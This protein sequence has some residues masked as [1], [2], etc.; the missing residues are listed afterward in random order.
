MKKFTVLAILFSLISLATAAAEEYIGS[1]TATKDDKGKVTAITFKSDDG[2]SYLVKVNSGST[3]LIK[4]AEGKTIQVKGKVSSAKNKEGKDEEWLNVGGFEF[5]AKGKVAVTKEN[6]K[7][8]GVSIGS[9]ELKFDGKAK[10]IAEKAENK[11]V[12]AI[13]KYITKSVGKGKEK[14]DKEYFVVKSFT[15]SEEAKKQE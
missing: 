12:V 13:G 8:T 7:I 1:A 6:T 5:V 10:N 15:V 14:A 9:T 11:E 2:K 3:K 4:Q